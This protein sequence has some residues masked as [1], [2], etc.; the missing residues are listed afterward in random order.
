MERK[1]NSAFVFTI[2]TVGWVGLAGPQ[3]VSGAVLVSAGSNW[4]YLEIPLFTA[5]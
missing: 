4:R 1:G 5:T 2:L 3:T